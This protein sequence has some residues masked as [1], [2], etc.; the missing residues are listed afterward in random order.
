MPS[1]GAPDRPFDFEDRARGQRVIFGTG[2]AG[3]LLPDVLATLGA[4]AV[5]VIGTRRELERSASVLDG[6]RP[7]LVWDE[8]EQH[9]PVEL[10]GR[11]TRAA[12]GAGVDALVAIG[13]GSAIGLAKAIALRPRP[14]SLPIVAVPTT[15]SGSEATSTWGLVERG[16]KTTGVDPRVLPAVIVYDAELTR[17]LP[18]GLSV[19]SGL[20]ALAHAVDA[21][22]APNASPSTDLAAVAAIRMLAA[23]LPLVACDP[24]SL[25]GREDALRGAYLAASV[26]SAAGSGLHHRMSHVL[27]GTFGL[28]HSETHAVVLAHVVAFNAP[29][30]PGAEVQIAAALGAPTAVGGL[31]ALR[32]RL[33]APTA[34]RELGLRESDIPAAVE[35][36]LAVVPASNPR[37]VTRGDLTALLRAAWAGQ[38]PDSPA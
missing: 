14:R 34:L 30:A 9:V 2:R 23:A 17:S 37:L 31:I 13:G 8:V 12:Q 4:R 22:W 18:R 19:S 32:D 35:Q 1:P 24:D 11:A 6:I 27:G 16:V 20:N 25:T 3:V 28:P 33:H 26:F 7:A 29:A 36:I 21:F 38:A 10:A 15:Y 5:M